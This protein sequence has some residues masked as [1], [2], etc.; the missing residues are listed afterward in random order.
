MM[1]GK[2][3]INR[4]EAE[5]CVLGSAAIDEEAAA[6]IVGELEPTAF[7]DP[8]LRKMFVVF[9]DG[10][11]DGLP[12]NDGAVVADRMIAAGVEPSVAAA[13]VTE[14]L[15][16]VP[17]QAH[18]RYYVSKLQGLLKRDH[19]RQLGE[20]LQGSAT[21]PTTD[22]DELIAEG[23]RTLG[24]LQS[25]RAANDL[26][27]AAAALEQYDSRQDSHA[28]ETGLAGLN[29]KLAGGF[30]AGQLVVVAGR[31]G[32]GKSCLLQQVVQVAA[33]GGR[34]G[35]VCSLEMTAGELAD[36]ALRTITREAFVDLPVW[37]AESA[38]LHRILGQIR[39]AVRI[40]RVGLVAVDYLGLI[41]SPR[42]RNVNRAEQV[43]AVTRSFKLLAR[44]VQVPI[45]LGCQLN[46]AAEHRER[47]QLS[48]LRESGAIEQDADVVILIH[49]PR[50]EQDTGR[51]LI[52]AKHRGGPCGKIDATFNGPQ[53]AFEDQV[54]DLSWATNFGVE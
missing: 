4:R 12:L 10:L 36:R 15:E 29:S 22:C 8:I 54:R 21:D 51:E 2:P 43:A 34:P 9:R 40:H 19:L 14:A 50:G 25:G 37:F 53:F 7:S 52:V 30:R 26:I 31:P 18:A 38:E 11:R 5:L 6:F 33:A 13:A 42:E 39:A 41:E 16:Q 28:I 1:H 20:R 45:L 27:D 44:E 23:L 32:S 17:H 47:P 46:R 49:S 35:L 24:G 3:A 48:D